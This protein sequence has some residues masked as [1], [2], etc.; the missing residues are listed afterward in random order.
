MMRTIEKGETMEEKDEYIHQDYPKDLKAPWKENYYFNFVDRKNRAWGIHHISLMR[1]TQQGRFSALYIVDDEVLPYSN[2][3]DIENLEETSDGTLSIK[4]VEPFKKYKVTFN[5]PNHQMDLDYEARFPAF[6]F[7]RPRET[8]ESPL[9][10]QHYRQSLI[11]K[12]TLTKDGKSRPIQSFCD[13]DHTWG[14]RNEGMITGW[15][16]CHAYFENKTL[17]IFRT[18]FGQ[19]AFGS[20]YL[21]TKEGNTRIVR[22]EVV[23]TQFVNGMPISSIFTG[24]D[25]DG[26]VLGKLKSE[27]F[28][29]LFLPMGEEGGGAVVH[30]NFSEFTDLE[31][32]EKGDGVDEYLINPNEEYHENPGEPIEF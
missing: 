28:S 23:D 11:A 2:L 6:D 27:K 3:I 14:Y 19:Y 24:Y 29:T 16:C 10:V 32:G 17:I 25:K 8:E 9:S 21:S 15:N 4:I 31:T 18:L 7:G 30:E 20:G 1:L 26:N 22:T 13:R 5:G 12:G